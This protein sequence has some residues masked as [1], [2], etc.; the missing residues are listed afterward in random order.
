MF[1]DAIVCV[2]DFGVETIP[3][4]NVLAGLEWAEGRIKELEQSLSMAKFAMNNHN[5]GAIELEAIV[6]Q[7]RRVLA[8][9][10]GLLGTGRQTAGGRCHENVKALRATIREA[11]ER[12]KE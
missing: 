6:E 10:D 2:R 3:P 11:A 4:E 1:K 5:E 9:T 12:A 7:T 8:E